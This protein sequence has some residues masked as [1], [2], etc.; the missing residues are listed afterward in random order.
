[1]TP[2]KLTT[3]DFTTFTN[4]VNGEPRNSKTKYNGV[5]PITKEKLWDVPV[6]TNDDIE[7]AVAAANKAY[8]QWRDTTWEERTE[9]LRQ[10]K[11]LLESYKE[12]MTVLLLKETGKPRMFG[13]AEV[14]IA[15]KFIDWHLNMKEPEI[16]RYEDD[17]KTIVN[18]YVPLGVA[19]AICPWNFPFILSLG[20]VLPAVQMGNAIIVK[21]S[22]F[23]P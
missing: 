18:K 10:F 21:P 11:E 14:D 7:D 1:M 20:K 15:S 6:A 3:V 17:E 4:I 9:K 12:E 22:P 13:G 23:T 2:S 16:N 5:D 19:A 8:L